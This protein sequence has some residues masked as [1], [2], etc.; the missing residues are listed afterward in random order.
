MLRGVSLITEM[1]KNFIKSA[2]S[3]MEKAT[4]FWKQLI[5]EEKKKEFWKDSN[6][7]LS[8]H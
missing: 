4:Q 6:N 3:I 2:G 1:I 5:P 8:Q 7:E